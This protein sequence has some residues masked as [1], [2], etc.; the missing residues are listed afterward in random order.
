MFLLLFLKQLSLCD[1]M[2][3]SLYVPH[4]NTFFLHPLS[5]VW[6]G[7]YGVVSHRRPPRARPHVVRLLPLHWMGG[8]HLLPPGWVHAHLLLLRVLLLISLLPGQQSFLLL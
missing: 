3:K 4:F 7:F 8:H 5:T 6:Y 2:L 1:D